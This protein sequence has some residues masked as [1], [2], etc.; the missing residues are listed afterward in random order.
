MVIMKET[1]AEV[2]GVVRT[3]AAETL[4]FTNHHTFLGFAIYP[5]SFAALPSR[6]LLYQI[7]PILQP[8]F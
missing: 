8:A 3:L 2:E 6:N 1:M 4:S 7:Q 5:A